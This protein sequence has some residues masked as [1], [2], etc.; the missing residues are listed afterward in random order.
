LILFQLYHYCFSNGFKWDHL[1][2]GSIIYYLGYLIGF[3]LFLIAGII[4][5]LISAGIKKKIYSARNRR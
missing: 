3:N 2:G 1:K 4:L 5:I